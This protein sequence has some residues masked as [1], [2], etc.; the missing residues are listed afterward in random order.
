MM[1]NELMAEQQMEAIRR[2]HVA[3]IEFEGQPYTIDASPTPGLRHA[4]A[5]T[6]VR[7]GM[8]LDRSAGEISTSTPQPSVNKEVR[9][10]M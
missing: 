2:L 3:W 8:M 7:L 4:V 1:L 10:A 9:H 6:L 5:A